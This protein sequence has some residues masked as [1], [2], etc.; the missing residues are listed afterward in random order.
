MDIEALNIKYKTLSPTERIQALYTDFH[1]VLLTSSFGTTSAIL[2]HLFKSIRPQQI[3]HF[4]DTTY[5][6][7]ETLEYKNHLTSLM[8]LKVI[9]IKAEEWKNQFTRDD[10]TWS[11]NPDFCCSINK[12]EPINEVKKGQEIWVSGLLGYQNEHRKQLDV[13]EQKQD[14]IKF[15]P[16]ID[17]KKEEVDLYI[18]GHQLPP[19]PLLAKG[20]ES[21]GCTHCTQKGQGRVGRWGDSAKTE[22]GLHL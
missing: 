9:D 20:Y 19:H 14:I 17:M 11:K 22:C 3:V 13:F 10:Q 8:D 15:Y 2:L 21:V 16:I 12:V 18:S 6:F 5:H 7:P 4:I 1:H